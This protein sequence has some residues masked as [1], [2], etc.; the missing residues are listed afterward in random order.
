MKIFILTSSL[1]GIAAFS[2]PY[3]L[4]SKKIRISGVV[5]INKI[6]SNKI[7]KIKKKVRKTL[8]IG[9]LGA[10]NGLRMRQWYKEDVSELL[11]YSDLRTV[12]S[13]ADLQLFEINNGSYKEVEEII[14]SLNA[15]LGISLENAYIP[16]SI[17]SIPKSG[18][19][20]V[21]HEL[22]PEYQNAQ[23]V[24][25]SIYNGL[26]RTGFTI[27]KVN[28]GIDKGDILYRKTAEIEFKNYLSTTVTYNCAK[29]W[30]DSAKGLLR[31][32]ENYQ[33]YDAKS[34]SQ[35]LGYKYT[36]PSIKQVFKIYRNFYSLKKQ[37]DIPQ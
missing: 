36:T 34:Y 28:R 15:D 10:L 22:L 20:N 25:W 18:M 1:N 23:S 7:S 6:S 3:L 19:I 14:K 13:K 9:V 29:L 27:H 2:L 30:K 21:H 16:E 5:L 8:K 11:K 35:G 12:C 17:F 4:S 26:D 33:H 32:I 31:L 24:I 37:K